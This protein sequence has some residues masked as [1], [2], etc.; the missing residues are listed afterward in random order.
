MMRQLS[1]NARRQDVKIPFILC[2]LI[3]AQIRSAGSAEIR[4]TNSISKDSAGGL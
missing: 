3:M 1:H 4:K 2:M